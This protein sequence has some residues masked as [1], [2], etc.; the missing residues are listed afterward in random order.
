MRIRF[1]LIALLA[2]LALC[3][4]KKNN[5]M[6]TGDSLIDAGKFAESV[7]YF[8]KA[9][10]TNP[11]D[12]GSLRGIGYAYAAL[13]KYELAEKY[14]N[15]A[16]RVNPKCA[17]CYNN[18]GRISW[19][20]GKMPQASGYFDRSVSIN[21]TDAHCYAIR[22]NFREAQ[23]EKLAALADYNKAIEL[24]PTNG[25]YYLMR[26]RY[27]TRAGYQPLALGDINK[28]IELDPQNVSFYV[29]RA[30]LY[31]NRHM[32]KEA[33]EDVDRGFKIDSN[34]YAL[35][36]GR[37]AIYGALQERELAIKD[38]N[39]A[40]SINPEDALAYYNRGL[41][42]YRLE[43][44]DGSCED[45][46]LAYERMKKTDPANEL[47]PEIESSLS[48]YCDSSRAS[49]YYQR[50]IALYNLLRYDKAVAVYTRGLK[51]FE[52]GIML[53]FRGNAYTMM[54][55]YKSA[56]DDYQK[57]ISMKDNI[58]QELKQNVRYALLPPDSM[59]AYVNGFMSESH[60]TAAECYLILKDFPN[61]LSEAELALSSF[62]EGSTGL[63]KEVLYNLRGCVLLASGKYSE[64]IKDFDRI[65]SATDKFSEAYA[66][67][68]LAKINLG[69]NLGPFEL[70]EQGAPDRP[71][72]MGMLLPVE[73]KKR[74]GTDANL[75]SALA[76]CDKAIAGYKGFGYAYYLRGYIKK[77]TDASDH[78]TDLTKALALQFPVQKELV[79]G[80]AK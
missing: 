36:T 24:D 69:G 20:Q 52:S 19:M 23:Q 32:L 72:N 74:K 61:A 29:E 39:K 3:A 4:Q 42:K 15:E 43:D 57:S 11:K 49:Y 80:C 63:K 44:M 53:T 35:Y 76:D 10:K 78:C 28:A 7:P 59:K 21:P 1:L 77:M 64:A 30:S 2:C 26:S 27:N 62:P 67:R 22:A 75:I 58:E 70:V 8:E 40:I 68:A 6:I 34:V 47:M 73:V 37:G 5:D 33:L 12:E 51:K 48:E 18:L 45:V 56:L 9:L 46:R 54:H 13:Q 25:E 17:R 41:E 60:R 31:Y 38:Y 14:Y 50:G 55:D 71:F 66:N 16:I 65:I 79:E